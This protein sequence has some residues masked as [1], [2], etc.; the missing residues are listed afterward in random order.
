MCTSTTPVR[1]PTPQRAWAAVLACW[2]AALSG[3]A[4][5]ATEEG[6]PPGSGPLLVVVDRDRHVTAPAGVCLQRVTALDERVC[7]RRP[8][9]LRYEEAV[10]DAAIRARDQVA[11]TAVVIDACGRRRTTPQRLLERLER[12][13]R[14]SRRRWSRGVLEDAAA[15]TCSVLEHGYLTRVE[16][17][18]GCRVAAARR[19]IEGSAAWSTATSG[20]T[21]S[22][23]SSRLDGRLFHDIAEQRDRDLERDLDAV[24]EARATTVRLRWGQV[25]RHACRTA[26]KLAIVMRRGGWDGE[27]SRCDQ[28]GGSGE[29]A[30]PDPPHTLRPRTGLTP[31]AA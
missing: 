22:R 28:C 9:R 25:F 8:P 26:A 31:D 19:R 10:I 13:G 2:P 29:P 11:A 1:S 14:V 18:T 3:D 4:A 6:R 21:A 5:L 30:S 16:R 24:V 20:T 15:G 12:R 17:P 27:L 7:N 23:W